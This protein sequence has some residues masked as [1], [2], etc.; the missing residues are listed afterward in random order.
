VVQEREGGKA[1]PCRVATCKCGRSDGDDQKKEKRKKI[2]VGPY[3]G[4]VSLRHPESVCT[5]LFV[6]VFLSRER[7][8][9]YRTGTG[10]VL[11]CGDPSFCCRSEANLQIGEH[12]SNFSQN[13]PPQTTWVSSNSGL[14]E[15]NKEKLRVSRAL[16]IGLGW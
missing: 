14:S 2:F 9:E 6:T 7:E 5:L 13:S 3:Q 8:R 4:R 16:G 12:T 11:V 1:E 15:I 10:I